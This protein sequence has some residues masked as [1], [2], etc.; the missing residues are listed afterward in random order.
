LP[1]HFK[2]QVPFQDG[3]NHLEQLASIFGV[4]ETH[5]N[6]LHIKFYSVARMNLEQIFID[7]SRKQFA[8][9]ESSQ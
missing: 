8:A 7:L 6:E 3:N 9:E 4:L 2:L 1:Y 5:Q